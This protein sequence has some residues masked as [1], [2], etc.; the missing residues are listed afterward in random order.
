MFLALRLS[1]KMDQA[2]T[3]GPFQFLMLGMQLLHLDYSVETLKL[4][5]ICY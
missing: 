5:S 2:W 4:S 1:M 3:G